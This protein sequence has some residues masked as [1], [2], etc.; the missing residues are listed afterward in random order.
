[1]RAFLLMVVF[2]AAALM[3]HP[4]SAEK[5][6][7]QE[8][9]PDGMTAEEAVGIVFTEIEKRLIH[10]Y[11]GKQ[12]DGDGKEGKG[13]SKQMPPGLAK[14]DELPPGLQQQ[15]VKNGTLPPGLAKRDLPPDLVIE[16]PAA[17][18]GTERKIVG[19]DV[20]L[21]QTATGIVLD[22]LEGVVTPQ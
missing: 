13:K 21:I 3:T 6:Y 17:K 22:V 20:V 5:P 11:Y 14:R 8:S 4:A 7:G 16:L 1:M 19:A 9:K 10:D 12:S 15:I 18:K 2:L